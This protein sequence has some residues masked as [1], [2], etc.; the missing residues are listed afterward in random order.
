[1]NFE[2]LGHVLV[3]RFRQTSHLLKF[4]FSEIAQLNDQA[5]DMIIL[6]DHTWWSYWDPNYTV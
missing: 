6:L 5:S 3:T 4:V 1:M 2:K